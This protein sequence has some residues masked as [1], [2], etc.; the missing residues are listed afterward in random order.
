MFE[1]AG[2]ADQGALRITLAA[3]IILLLPVA[4]IT[5]N[6]RVAISEK[7]VYDHSVRQYG[8]A[9]ISGIPE[10]ELIRAN[11][12]VRDYL[13]TDHPGP[14]AIEVQDS[15]GATESLFSAKETSHMA[16]VRD[17]VQL[18]FTVEVFAIAAVLTAATALTALWGPRVLAAASLYAA[19]LTAGAVAAAGLF[20]AAGFDSAWSQ[21]HGIAFSNDLWQLD[22]D[23]DHLIQMYPEDFWFEITAI[24][25]AVTVL[26]ASVIALASGVYLFA[27]RERAAVEATP[28]PHEL[29]ERPELPGR[30]G[31]ARL[32]PPDTRNYIR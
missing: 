3:A 1:N 20:A 17:L 19:L 5:T 29:P 10:S 24:L 30:T 23:T 7:S 18:M 22:P 16:D 4:L 6:I 32:S 13:V 27:T 31:H 15:A 26:E 25:G 14:L 11:Q 2:R 9:D 8:A 21:F 28:V 12:E